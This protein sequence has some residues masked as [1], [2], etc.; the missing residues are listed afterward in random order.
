MAPA[1]IIATTL[2]ANSKNAPHVLPV[3]HHPL[4]VRPTPGNPARLALLR[5]AP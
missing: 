5:D 4:A 1:T 2:E 3:L